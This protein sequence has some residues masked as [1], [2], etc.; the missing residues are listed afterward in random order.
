[1]NTRFANDFVR[2]LFV[3]LISQ[4][5]FASSKFTHD[6]KR[7][8]KRPNIVYA[9]SSEALRENKNIFAWVGGGL[10]AAEVGGGYY[11]NPDWLLDLRAVYQ[12]DA[13][14]GSAQLFALSVSYFPL[15]AFYGRL[16]L[17]YRIGEQFNYRN[18]FVEDRLQAKTVHDTGIE[19]ALGHRWQWQHFS[20]GIEWASLYVPV[21]TPHTNIDFQ[22][23][24]LTLQLGVSL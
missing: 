3:L 10:I 16:G 24:L 14:E 11:L 7:I 17:A 9:D 19:G 8:V 1:M 2:I 15:N 4:H 12:K 20:F 21:F 23:R 6:G 5:S 18:L 22:F 13:V